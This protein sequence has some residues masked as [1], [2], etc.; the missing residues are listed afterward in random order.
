MSPPEHS[1]TSARLAIL[2][3]VMTLIGWSSVPLFLKHFSYAID[4]WTSNG[5]R[6]GLS[7]LLW[8]PVL[9]VGALRRSLPPGLWRASIVPALFN[10]TGQ[11]AFTWGFYQIDPGLMTFGLR[12]Q[13]LFVA[14][15]A[16]LLFPAE[17]RVIREPTFILGG[18]LVLGGTLSLLLM[19]PPQAAATGP[20]SIGAVEAGRLFG[21]GLAVLSGLLF[22]GYALSVRHYMRRFPSIT[23][24]AAISQYT[25]AALVGMMLWLGQDFGARAWDLSSGQ[26]GLLLLSAVIGI[27]L[28]HV[29]Y[30]ASIARLGV[31]VSSGVVQLQPI[32]VTAA[33]WVLFGERMSPV[34]IGCGVTAIIGA[35]IV[36]SVQHRLSRR[37]ARLR[38]VEA[39]EAEQA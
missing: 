33:S 11:T 29:F 24:F 4:A 36:L 10:A 5:W 8:A 6:Y 19:N 32:L 31:A 26:L 22:A 28:G 18:C 25:A 20:A 7:A 39:A 2:L 23:A 17:R 3:I 9:I 16:F 14:V 21:I 37:D 15:G 34:Q 27:A 1:R 13:I 12:L 35:G 30:Y 38:E